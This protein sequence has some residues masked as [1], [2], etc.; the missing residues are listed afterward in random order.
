MRTQNKSKGQYLGSTLKNEQTR[1][2]PVSARWWAGER[3]EEGGAETQFKRACVTQ[4]RLTLQIMH[5]R[6]KLAHPCTSET[7]YLKSWSVHAHITHIQDHEYAASIASQPNADRGDKRPLG[8]NFVQCLKT[9]RTMCKKK[10]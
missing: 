7:F 8:N 4:G 3:D 2:Y 1:K 6:K 10:M 5:L 9:P